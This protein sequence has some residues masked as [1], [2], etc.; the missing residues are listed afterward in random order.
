MQMNDSEKTT[1]NQSITPEPLITVFSKHLHWLDI[2]N[3][4]KTAAG[5][6]FDGIDL[7]VRP[8]GHVL[9]E[10][11]EEE[12]PKAVETCKEA[13]IEVKMICTS[14]SDTSDPLTEKILKTAGQLGIKY[15]RM[16]WYHYNPD[17]HIEKNLE[18]FKSKMKEL[19]QLNE[20]YQIKG[21]YQNHEGQWFGAP[22]WDLGIILNEINSE[23]LGIQYD[24]LNASIEGTFSWQIGLNFIA[25]FIHTIDIK[26]GVW[27]K[28]TGRWNLDYVPL[29]RGNVDFKRFF[30]FLRDNRINVPYSMHFEYDLGGA[31]T[32]ARQLTIPGSEVILAMKRDLQNLRELL[33]S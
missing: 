16:N 20:T 28:E 8:K 31:D 22:V 14:I 2:E 23:W 32:G 17:Q 21:A 27:N 7:T 9:P 12:L 15:Y 5:I 4:A 1:Q 3:M 10:R 19:A 18:N 11:A 24:I 26:D 6:G 30:Q 29:G 13:G 25:S 33:R